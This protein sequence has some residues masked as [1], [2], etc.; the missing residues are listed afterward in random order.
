MRPLSAWMLVLLIQVPV[1]AAVYERDLLSP[2]DGLLTYDHVSQREWL[3]LPETSGLDLGVINDAV[4]PGGPWA[5]F[6]FATAEDVE[7]LAISAGVQP[8]PAPRLD[9]VVSG[10]EAR[11]LIRLLGDI[12]FGEGDLL[13]EYNIALGQVALGFEGGVPIFDDTNFY[14][15]SLGKERTPG[16]IDSPLFAS[17]GGAY[18]ISGPFNV[19]PGVPSLGRGTMGPFWLYRLT[20]PEPG[21]SGLWLLVMGALLRRRHPFAR[22]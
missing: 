14:V 16:S 19:P 13:G 7:Q 17:I 10:A 4:K 6:R 22:L 2:G 1:A 9:S 18:L 15:V 11:K 8:S 20:I 12:I 5:G 21:F 3:D